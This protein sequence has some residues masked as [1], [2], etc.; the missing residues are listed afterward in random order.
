MWLQ[1]RVFH[2][3]RQPYIDVRRANEDLTEVVVM[4]ARALHPPPGRVRPGIDARAGGDARRPRG[5]AGGQVQPRSP[6][7]ADPFDGR[8]HR[9]RVGWQITLELSNV[10]RLPI[11]IYPGM[12]IG[13]ISFLHDHTG[14]AA[15]PRQVPGTVRADGVGVPQELP[16]S[17]VVR[18]AAR[19]PQQRVGDHPAR[20]HRAQAD[21]RDAPARPPGARA[22]VW[23]R[24]V[25]PCT[26]FAASTNTT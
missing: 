4:P 5:P 15:V 14:R 9:P 13:Q 21:G 6:G 26:R 18:T 3:N 1:F 16:R 7:P 10:A 8:I 24:P 25:T 12:A 11:T 2:N 17:G 22:G 23:L 19:R 20:K